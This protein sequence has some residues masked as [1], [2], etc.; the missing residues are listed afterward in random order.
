[1]L[2]WIQAFDEGILGWVDHSLEL[3]WSWLGIRRRWVLVGM[4]AIWA[5]WHIFDQIKAEKL[6]DVWEILFLLF[7]STMRVFDFLREK[8]LT[9]SQYNGIRLMFR[10][11]RISTS[12]RVVFTLFAPMS[13]LIMGPSVILPTTFYML[14]WDGLVPMG[15]R[16][17]IRLPSFSWNQLQ[18]SGA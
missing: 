9:A 2:R 12:F 8:S 7:N 17:K 6:P 3:A 15:P 16:K 5:G 4:F 18:M 10:T 1:M 11:G 13:L 14:F